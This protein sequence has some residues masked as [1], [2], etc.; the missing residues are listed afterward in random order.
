MAELTQTQKTSERVFGKK[1]G[2][3]TGKSPLEGDAGVDCAACHSDLTKQTTAERKIDLNM[4][5]CINCHT[6]K[7]VS[8]DCEYKLT[9]VLSSSTASRSHLPPANANARV[10]C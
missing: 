10:W 1:A 2:A 3:N 8:I 7:K 6:Q 4:G 9:A 5:F